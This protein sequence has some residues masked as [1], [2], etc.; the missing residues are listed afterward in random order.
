MASDVGNVDPLQPE[1]CGTK[2]PSKTRKEQRLTV[3][4]VAV[5]QIQKGVLTVIAPTAKVHLDRPNPQSKG[6]TPGWRQGTRDSWF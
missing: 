6:S 3:I 1:I 5:Q 4:Y 2:R